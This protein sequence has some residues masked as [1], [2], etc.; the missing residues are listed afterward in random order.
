MFELVQELKDTAETLSA[1]APRSIGLTAG[2]QLFIEFVTL[3]PHESEVP[4]SDDIR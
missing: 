2:C 4:I 1:E 3:F